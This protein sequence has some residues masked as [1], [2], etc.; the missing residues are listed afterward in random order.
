MY[1]YVFL[2]SVQIE[3]FKGKTKAMIYFYNFFFTSCEE[4]V[5]S[6]TSTLQLVKPTE[7]WN[8]WKQR[9]YRTLEPKFT[10]LGSSLL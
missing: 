7:F 9:Y 3:I 4:E 8:Y 1:V 2:T 6:I 5:I 10:N